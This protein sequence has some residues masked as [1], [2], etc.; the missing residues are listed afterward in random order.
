MLA[1]VIISLLPLLQFFSPLTN[2]IL[3]KKTRLKNQTPFLFLK[4]NKTKMYHMTSS[5]NI[6]FL[7]LV[8]MVVGCNL[9]SPW[10]Q[11]PLFK[12]TI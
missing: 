11:L 12:F 3:K 7:T 9:L 8:S 2:L 5:L 6:S 1:H 4:Q 10:Q